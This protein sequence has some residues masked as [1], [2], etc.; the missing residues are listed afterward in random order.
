MGVGGLLGTPLGV[1]SILLMLCCLIIVGGVIGQEGLHV[2]HLARWCPQ[3]LDRGHKVDLALEEFLGAHLPPSWIAILPTILGE[4]LGSA[5][6]PTR[7]VLVWSAF[8]GVVQVVVRYVALAGGSHVDR[9][10][11]CVVPDRIHNF[12]GTSTKRGLCQHALLLLGVATVCLRVPLLPLLLL[13]RQLEALIILAV[14]VGGT[15]ECETLS[16]CLAG[17]DTRGGDGRRT[18]LQ[19]VI[20]VIVYFVRR[21]L[22]F[23]H[24]H[25]KLICQLL[26]LPSRVRCHQ[27]WVGVGTPLPGVLVEGMKLGWWL[28]SCSS[29]CNRLRILKLI[30]SFY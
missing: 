25:V 18:R 8:F 17:A 30:I 24:L 1:E 19:D 11:L 4:F 6:H 29:H 3:G 13:L 15:V 2:R 14:H 20:G 5:A 10:L 27:R 9:W 12:G 22:D 23:L 26:E 7:V 21:L 16:L 28:L